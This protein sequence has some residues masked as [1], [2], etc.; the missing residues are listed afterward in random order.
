MR[1]PKNRTTV[2]VTSGIIGRDDKDE[3]ENPLASKIIFLGKENLEK[4]RGYKAFLDLWPNGQL[5]MTI[6]G[7]NS[8]S[9]LVLFDSIDRMKYEEIHGE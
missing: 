4:I 9:A 3:T 7:L 2:D 5:C 1:K 6:T 8:K